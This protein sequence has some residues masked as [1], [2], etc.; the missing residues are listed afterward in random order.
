MGENIQREWDG[1]P[2]P[3]LLWD[4]LQARDKDRDTGLTMLADL[5]E[6]GSALA[7]MYLGHAYVSNE[8]EPDEVALGEQW[9]IRSA[10]SGSIEGRYLL[11][12]HYRMRDDWEKALPEME[13]L[14]AQGYAPGMYALGSC[15]YWGRECPRSVPQALRYLTM[16]KDGGHLPA[17]ALLAWIYRKEKFGLGGRIASHWNCAAKIPALAWY[18]LRYPNSDRLRGDQRLAALLQG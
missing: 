1:E 15:L 12:I 13:A 17:R 18:A 6:R 7:M 3:D 9:L 2:F 16:A 10:E 4:A 11:S 14:A 8:S 5:A